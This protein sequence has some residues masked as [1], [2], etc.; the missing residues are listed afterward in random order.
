MSVCPLMVTSCLL[1]F[2]LLN[3]SLQNYISSFPYPQHVVKI[4]MQENLMPLPGCYSP[5]SSPSPSLGAAPARQRA[6]TLRALTSST[7]GVCCAR[8]EQAGF[9]YRHFLYR[10]TSFWIRHSFPFLAS[11]FFASQPSP[12]LTPHVKLY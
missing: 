1:S 6:L 9:G 10:L 5:T 12:L 7:E 2:N 8:H 3:F 11:F 4:A